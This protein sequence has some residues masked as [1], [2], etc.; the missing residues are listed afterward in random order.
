[1]LFGPYIGSFAD[2]RGPRILSIAGFGLAAVAYIAFAYIEGNTIGF[3]V[4]IWLLMTLLG[5]SLT[6][7][8]TS[9][10]VE[11]SVVVD[12]EEK[13]NPEAFGP[14]GAMGQAF[15]IRS[16]V[17]ATEQMVGPVGTGLL[18]GKCGWAGTCL[19]FASV[20]AV[21]TCL[22]FLFFGDRSKKVK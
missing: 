16:M 11:I 12:L 14:G 10:M 1:M 13:K 17:Y 3:K 8:Q 7:I 20:N 4:L 18:M 21:C 9:N 19:F 15:A 22:M 2:R 5:F 6:F